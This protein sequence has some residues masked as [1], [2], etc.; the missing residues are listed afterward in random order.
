MSLDR[1]LR[2]FSSGW[3]LT[4]LMRTVQVHCLIA[5]A[6]L[7]ACLVAE[8]RSAFSLTIDRANAWRDISSDNTVGFLL[9]DQLF[10]GAISVQ[11][12][13]PP[14]T[15]SATQNGLTL[16]LFFL[17]GGIGDVA[18]GQYGRDFAYN[19]AFT[20]SW[21]LSGM[22]GSDTAT[23]T[24]PAPGGVTSMP[25]ANNVTIGGVGTTPTF[26][27]MLPPSSADLVRIGIFDD[28]QPAAPRKPIIFESGAIALATTSFTVPPGTLEAG[29]RYVARVELIE[30]YGHVFTADAQ[31]IRSRSNSFFSLVP[32]RAGAPDVVYLPTVKGST[33]DFDLTVTTGKTFFLDPPV[34]IGYQ[35][36]I[37]AGNPNF[38]SVLLPSIGDGQFDLIG[39]NG[40]SLGSATAGVVHSF[41]VGGVNCFRVLGI[42]ASAG[43][44]PN[45]PTAFI[46]G[47]TFTADGEF[48]GTMDPIVTPEPGTLL[49][50]GTTMVGSGLAARRRRRGQN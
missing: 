31:F 47:L 25:F 6:L 10:F 15:V 50:L 26:S 42:E 40:A 35:Y 24:T 14:T 13:G 4:A 8:P 9:G 21:S 48:T 18:P 19:P 45:D 16:P 44:D 3:Q 22:R 5:A 36:A 23:A 33:F 46:T 34:A 49:L 30:T 32:L 20:G 41:G 37:G 1:V 38:A 43:L 39:C 29:H 12:A 7:I 11:P 28:E 27:W 17:G 2:L